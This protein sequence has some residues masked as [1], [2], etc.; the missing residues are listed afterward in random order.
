MTT[1]PPGEQSPACPRC[2][3]VN[4][5]DAL[6]C[7]GCGHDL[8]DGSGVPAA[9]SIPTPSR[10]EETDEVPAARAQGPAGQDGASTGQDGASTGQPEWVAEIWVD[11]DWYAVQNSADPMPAPGRTEV[12]ALRQPSL[13][14]GR[15][16]RHLGVHPDI[17]CEAD[18]GVS[19]RQAQLSR[20]G[21]RW[22]VEDLR[23]ANGTYLAAD[24]AP[25]PRDPI[26]PGRRVEVG[27][28]DRLYL[29]AWTRMVIRP[30]APGEVDPVAR[31]GAAG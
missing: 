14:V 26:A 24:G 11:P 25:L 15:A 2:R 12:V 3:T 18:S 9:S 13:L 10:P 27:P 5:P 16:S 31:D 23:S 29:G 6:Y 17:D 4:V 22:F 8:T 20:D 1:S 28:G 19:R 30:A 21:G 7:E